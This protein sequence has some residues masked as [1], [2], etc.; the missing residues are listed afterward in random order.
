[1]IRPKSVQATRE[2]MVS[3]SNQRFS[4]IWLWIER[5]LEANTRNQR[6]KNPPKCCPH[7]VPQM[8]CSR[9]FDQ[10]QVYI[11]DV[12][13]RF[14]LEI[15]NR[16]RSLTSTWRWSTKEVKI[17]ETKPG[18]QVLT[19]STKQNHQSNTAD[20]RAVFICFLKKTPLKSTKTLHPFKTL[21]QKRAKRTFHAR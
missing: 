1:M 10:S 3:S 18:G 19:G 21:F 6:K 14:K 15:G 12:I 13:G 8:K 2:K 7:V 9:M 20:N 11:F 4:I 16:E 17:K 5:Y